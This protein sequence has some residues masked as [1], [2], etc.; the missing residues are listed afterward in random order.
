MNVVNADLEDRK[1]AA[2]NVRRCQIDEKLSKNEV[3]AQYETNY[4]DARKSLFPKVVNRRNK[5]GEKD[6]NPKPE[7]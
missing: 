1:Q 2:D 5:G 3:R 7:E 4:L 6:L